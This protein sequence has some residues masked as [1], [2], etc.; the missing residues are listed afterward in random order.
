MIYDYL[1]TVFNLIVGL[2]TGKTL[3]T[4]AIV[5]VGIYIVWA[6][7]VVLFSFGRKFD[8]R[9]TKLTK[10][11]LSNEAS[12]QNLAEIYEKSKKI[13]S[14]L[15]HGI[16]SYQ[17]N[18]SGFP[19]SYI[20][21]R[22]ALDSEVSGG[23]FNHGKSLM[24]A[25]I[26][27]C[28]IFLFVF[29]AAY[30]ATAKAFTG[31]L[32]AQVAIL[33]VVFFA[34]IRIFYF[35]YT[36]V[37]Q[38]LYR[39]DVES[40]Y[41]LVD[42]L[43]SKYGKRVE[44]TQIV[45]VV[46]QEN[47]KTSEEELKPAEPSQEAEQS[48]EDI[49]LNL[50]DNQ[51]EKSEV[52]EV[53]IQ[54]Q[55]KTLDDYD[56][57]KKKNID[58]EKLKGEVPASSSVLPYIDV[59]SDYVIKDDENAAS[60]YHPNATNGSEML[61]GIMHNT[62]AVKKESS[63]QEKDEIKNENVE[64]DEEKTTNEVSNNV[65]ET[66]NEDSSSSDD[67]FGDIFSSLGDYAVDDEAD[68]KE[69]A[70]DIENQ[71]KTEDTPS[72]SH[73]DS[74]NEEDSKTEDFDADKIARKIDEIASENVDNVATNE[75]TATQSE[76]YANKLAATDG[77]KSKAKSQ[78][79]TSE[80]IAQ[81][82]GKF[83]PKSKLAS[84][85]VVIERNNEIRES[86]PQTPKKSKVQVVKTNNNAEKITESTGNTTNFATS[87][88][89]YDSYNN[90]V[91]AMPNNPYMQ[92]AYQNLQGGYMSDPM[93]GTFINMGGNPYGAPYGG[94]PNP[95]YDPNYMQGSQGNFYGGFNG[96]TPEQFGGMV[97]QYNQNNQ[98]PVTPKPQKPKVQKTQSQPQKPKT[99]E[100]KPAVKPVEEVVVAPSSPK[101]EVVTSSSSAAAKRGRPAKQV[102]DG[103]VTIKDDKEFEQVLSRAEK[104]MRKSEEGLSPS[105]AKR[106]EKELKSLLDALSKYKENR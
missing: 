19:S 30:L 52:V 104:L 106:V 67:I 18:K 40:F 68:N 99:Q 73:E 50:D 56:F 9:C 83:K 14:G 97:E 71:S 105:Q 79:K 91:G 62:L 80:N 5:A 53:P 15:A 29:N 22:E 51:E 60:S 43:D 59:D 74:G 93:G 36:S 95:P 1:L 78:E 70:S 6:L 23:I 21:R 92:G 25:Y 49:N 88:N 35:L 42:A 8:K 54:E 77:F 63:V 32:I 103:E 48:E 2:L 101:E 37:Q 84:G 102:F 82:V 13:S 31:T 100:K 34:V 85:G 66:Q 16:K 90:G 38:Q 45:Q 20:S 39:M 17:N 55:K 26:Y 58:V 27:L 4:A 11:I 87:Q 76:N 3:M 10:F 94:Y 69:V 81:I 65:E 28:T 61:G 72:L 75:E 57:F 86:Q 7:L 24:K 98:A 64:A 12:D 47:T 41:E 89:Y 44:S 33:P 96:S 46:A